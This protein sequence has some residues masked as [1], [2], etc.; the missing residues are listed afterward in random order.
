MDEIL[1]ALEKDSEIRGRKYSGLVRSNLGHIRSSV[2]ADRAMA[3]NANRVRDY[4]AKRQKDEAAAST[5]NHEVKALSR[6][7][8]LAVEAGTLTQVPKLPRLREDN[9]RQGFFEKPEFE[10][11]MAHLKD[12]DLR[13]FCR[14]AYLTG[15]RKGEIASLTWEAYD[16]ET[17]TLRLHARNAKSGHGR[18]IPLEGGGLVVMERRIAARR[19]D[20]RLIFHRGGES[21]GDFRK[22]WQ[23]A[24]VAAGLGQYLRDAKGRIRG[25][26][27]KLFHD[28]RR[29][30]VRNMVRAGNPENVAMKISGHKT[31]EIF[32]RYDITSDKDI[33]DA[34]LKTDTYRDSLPSNPTVA[35][36]QKVN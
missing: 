33:R 28:F 9:A 3:I 13:D 8:V 16:R 7:F 15:M 35:T 31:R 18:Q 26:Q 10:S 20:C 19:L 21:I 6:A 1:K 29:S 14:W 25:Y 2:G 34:M 36:L 23:A 27:G 24:C 32:D 30:A 12:E 4:I 22:S 17:K 5:I 11:V